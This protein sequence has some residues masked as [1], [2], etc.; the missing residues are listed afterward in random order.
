MVNSFFADVF[1]TKFVDHEGEED[2]FGGILPKGR[3]SRNGLVDKLA[4]VDLE[5]IVCNT[6]GLFQSWHAFA[7]LQV[8]PSVGYE[9]VEVVQGN[10]FFRK[11]VQ[12]DLHIFISC[13]RSIVIKK[14]IS[15]VRK[16]AWGWIWFCSKGT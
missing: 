3:G 1:D 10:N 4:Y 11:Y 7:D 9:L 5:P 15:R 12:A 2:I 6:A 8:H 16:R 13:H 14:Y